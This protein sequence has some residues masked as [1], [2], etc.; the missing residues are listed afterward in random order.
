MNAYEALYSDKRKDCMW[1]GVGIGLGK[2]QCLLSSR[3][4]KKVLEKNEGRE[5]YVGNHI[6]LNNSHLIL[7]VPLLVHLEEGEGISDM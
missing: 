4:K 7:K 3:C 1:K 2:Q 6:E 5:V